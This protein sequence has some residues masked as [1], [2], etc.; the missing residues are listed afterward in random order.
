MNDF[1]TAPYDDAVK[2]EIETPYDTLTQDGFLKP[3]MANR[4]GDPA[5]VTWWRHAAQTSWSAYF[6]RHRLGAVITHMRMDS[7]TVRTAPQAVIT[8]HFSSRLGRFPATDGRPQRYGGIDSLDLFNAGSRIGGLTCSWLWFRLPENGK[9][10]TLTEAP[11]EFPIERVLPAP[12]AV[13]EPEGLREVSTF[14]WA[15]RETDL[16]QHVNSIA[17]AE[18]CENTL[19]DALPSRTALS[20]LEIWY[21]KPAFAGQAAAGSASVS[22]CLHHVLLRG[23]PEGPV[24]CVAR[25]QCRG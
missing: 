7:E 23:L 3:T 18:R 20:S 10:G 8:V 1:L 14:R 16:N 11:P 6:E 4:F 15:D 13:V 17:L 22:E 2:I 12:P 9:P 19:A 21:L 24:F 25:L 5:S